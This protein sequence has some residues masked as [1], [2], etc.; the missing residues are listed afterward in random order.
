MIRYLKGDATRPELDQNPGMIMHICNNRG[1][2]GRGFVVAVS[3]RWPQ[4]EAAYRKWHLEGVSTSGAP[5]QLG[6]TQ[7]VRVE[8][9]LSVINMI[10][11]EGYGKN[12]TALHQTD[13][14]NATPP[15]RYEALEECL[16][17]VAFTA[18]LAGATLHAP[19]M[20]TGL[21]GGQW[22]RIEEIIERTLYEIPV[23]IYDL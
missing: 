7:T 21:A 14:A 2:W 11:Q 16:M 10:A 19:R 9:N 13:E 17:K 6:Q 23:T 22:S 5:F 20:G 3:K 18:T 1:G 8:S 12:N 15:I 4:P